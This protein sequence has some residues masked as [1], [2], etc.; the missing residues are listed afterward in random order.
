MLAKA[1]FFS[2]VLEVFEAGISSFGYKVD[3]FKKL[4]TAVTQDDAANTPKA[5]NFNA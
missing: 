3:A 5:S 1:R 2:P 4:C